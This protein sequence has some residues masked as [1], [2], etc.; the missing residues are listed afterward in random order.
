MLQQALALSMQTEG[1]ASASFE[2]SIDLG[3]MT[4]EEQ[5]NYV[6]RMSM[7]PESN[8]KKDDETKKQDI[9]ETVRYLTGF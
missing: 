6:L 7:Q 2:P 4:E 9:M 5:I 8:V 3:A 1:V